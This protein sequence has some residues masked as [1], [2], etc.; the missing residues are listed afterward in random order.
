MCCFKLGTVVPKRGLLKLAFEQVLD[1][2]ILPQLDNV[3]TRHE[4]YL[5]KVCSWCDNQ[6]ID[7]G[8]DR[9]D[10]ESAAGLGPRAISEQVSFRFQGRLRMSL[11]EQPH[12]HNRVFWLRSAVRLS[13]IVTNKYKQKWKNGRGT[14]VQR[15]PEVRV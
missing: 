1:E 5:A 15:V 2:G 10:E 12:K 8:N 13:R 7:S 6:R 14:D 11:T 9:R 4:V 3:V